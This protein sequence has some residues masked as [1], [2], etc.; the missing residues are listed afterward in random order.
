LSAEIAMTRI[1]PAFT[2]S[3]NSPNPE[4]PAATCEPRIAACA[5]PPPE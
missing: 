1:L 4:M 5:A 2:C 3:A